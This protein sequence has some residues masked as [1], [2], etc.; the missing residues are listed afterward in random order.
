MAAEGMDGSDGR[1]IDIPGEGKGLTPKPYFVHMCTFCDARRS[2]PTLRSPPECSAVRLPRCTD[3]GR[4]LGRQTQ[5]KKPGVV[6]QLS[7]LELLPAPRSMDHGFAPCVCQPPRTT[8][9]GAH[10]FP[11]LDHV[12]VL[13]DR[14]STAEIGC[15]RR[16]TTRPTTPR[17]VMRALRT[18]LPHQDLDD[19]NEGA[20]AAPFAKPMQHIPRVHTHVAGTDG[21]ALHGRCSDRHACSAVLCA[22]LP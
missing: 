10:A 17:Q 19:R 11:L 21:V 6:A 9:S 20:L 3:R 7:E 8:E 4:P 13:P 12:A 14:S 15:V 22:R 18:C 1:A 2:R 5:Q 16:L